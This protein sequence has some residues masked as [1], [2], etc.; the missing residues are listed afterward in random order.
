MLRGLAHKTIAHK[1]RRSGNRGHEAPGRA[2]QSSALIVERAA[3]HIAG[4]VVMTV[5]LVALLGSAVAQAEPVPD[6][7]P[8]TWA[9]KV[10]EEFTGAGLNKALWTGGW[11]SNASVTGPISEECE[12]AK[13]VYQPGNGYIYLQLRKETEK[14]N[15]GSGPTE[16]TGAVIESN[17]SDG[18]PGHSGFSYTY[19]VVEWEA[20][21]PGVA[22]AGRGCPTHGCMPDWPAL[23]SLSS[24][25]ADEIDTME[26]LETLGQACYHIHPPV[27]GPGACLSS[28]YAG[29][30]HKFA[31]EWEPGVVKYFYDGTEVGELSSGELNGT[32]QYLIATM[33]YPGCCN[34]PVQVPDEMLINY[35]RVWQHPPPEATTTSAS[36]VQQFQATLKGSVNPKGTDTHYYFQYGPTTSYGSTVPAPPG[37]DAGAG[38]STLEES[39][40]ATG[41]LAGSTY[42]YRIVASNAAGTTYG[43]DQAFSTELTSRPA[44]VLYPNGNQYV[45]YRGTS[46]QLFFWVWSASKETW[47]LNWLESTHTM[48][49]DPTAVLY[50]NG[51]QYVYYRGTSG[52]LFFWVWNASK[53]TWTL[54]WLEST[55]TM[56]G[57][58]T[59]V[60]YPSGSQ[61]VY[62]RGTSGQLF[63][64]V[65]SA[66]KETW[67]LNWLESTHTM[68]GDPTAVLYPNG[69]Q[70]V[71]YRG[72][73][74]QLFFWVWSASKETW[75]LNWLESTHTMAG[76]PTAVLYP[77]GNQ[78]VYYRGTSGQLFFWV[79]N[80]SKETWTLNWLESTHTM[81]G[82]PTAVLYPSGSQYVYYGGTNGQLF[83]WL[84]NASKETWALNWE[85]STHLM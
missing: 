8:G 33:V 63:F 29:A 10:N 9:L 34:Q 20:Y 43:T 47:T 68:A 64:W 45:Y 59:A 1:P 49:G 81:G 61:Y 25:N 17:P 31:S 66:S 78:Y 16:Y 57:E 22:P 24:T 69:N 71:Y 74:G 75:T 76:D 72:T 14:V 80:A 15:C 41:L 3:R 42:H 77:N 58:P 73:S 21:V 27:K 19:G 35:V 82:E 23:W 4:L 7:I 26:G 70:Y 60:L 18:Q 40:T 11:Q 85:E 30:W 83:F 84:W 39:A 28:S 46:G 53:E 67:T 52:Q 54:N 38:T 12:A 32:A 36:E 13:N 5:A 65:W 56:G 6:N 37:T 62:Y 50:P 55:H 2:E 44:S 79:W 51:N 48:A